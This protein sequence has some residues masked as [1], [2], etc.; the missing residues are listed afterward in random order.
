MTCCLSRRIEKIAIVRHSEFVHAI[1]RA[2]SSSGGSTMGDPDLDAGR[3]SSLT[4]S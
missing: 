4:N 3:F 1:D 2:A